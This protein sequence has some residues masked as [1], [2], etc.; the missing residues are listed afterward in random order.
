MCC[1]AL[2]L[3]F[4]FILRR[5][6][7]RT[8][9][10]GVA[11]QLAAAEREA[12]G[13]ACLAVL[14]GHTATV[15]ALLAAPCVDAGADAARFVLA[16]ASLDGALRLWD[17][18]GGTCAHTTAAHAEGGV[19]WA[20]CAPDGANLATAGA[21]GALR[22]WRLDGRDALAA[23]PTAV[24]ALQGHSARVTCGAFTLD[25]ER[26][27]SGAA[28]CSVRVWRVADGTC[29]RVLGLHAKYITCMVRLASCMP[30]AHAAY[31]AFSSVLTSARAWR[32]PGAIS[33]W[34]ARGQCL[35]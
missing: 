29:E 25:S 21:D 14:S 12:G 23:A 31:I 6:D 17:A 27:I 18:A 32:M 35:R 10:Q 22:L 9:A 13:Q 3:A 26:L 2:A 1:V 8:V 33:G 20:S 11:E 34:R 24:H 4:W 16:T 7:A 19:V 30:Q 5:A 28:D 15:T